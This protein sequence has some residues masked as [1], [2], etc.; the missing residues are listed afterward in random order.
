MMTERFDSY[1]ELALISLSI[2]RLPQDYGPH[3]DHK[4]LLDIDQVM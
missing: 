1:L 3:K 2:W 4:A